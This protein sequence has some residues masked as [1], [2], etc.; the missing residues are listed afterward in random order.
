MKKFNVSFLA[1]TETG[2][3]VDD[4]AIQDYVEAED[5]DEAISLALQY[6]FDTSDGDREINEGEQTITYY[7]EG[8][9][10]KE[11]DYGFKAV[12]VEDE[13]EENLVPIPGAERLAELK[14]EY[15]D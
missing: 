1:E 5:A 11:F 2:T 9:S 8:G 7:D 6:L 15:T 10:I 12:E 4:D 14:A 13:I 3:V